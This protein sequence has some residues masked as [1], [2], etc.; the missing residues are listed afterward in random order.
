MAIYT[1]SVA[2]SAIWSSYATKSTSLP[3]PLASRLNVWNALLGVLVS[4]TVACLCS[5]AILAAKARVESSRR[6]LKVG[7]LRPAIVLYDE[8]HPQG[9]FIGAI[10]SSDLCKRPDLLII[11]GTSLKVYGLKKL[12][13]DF[14]KAVHSS[15]AKNGLGGGKVIFV[16]ITEPPGSEWNDVIDYH[17]QGT[18]DAWVSKVDLDWHRI[19]PADWE[20]QTT[21]LEPSRGM[22]V[23][24]APCRTSHKGNVIPSY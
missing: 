20:I 22:K 14:A 23:V 24:K 2:K 4:T 17:V 7:S 19:R 8:P 5:N 10:Q 6:A 12:V 21:L 18:T 9:D 16:N 15:P 3:F 1:K 11:M 13:K